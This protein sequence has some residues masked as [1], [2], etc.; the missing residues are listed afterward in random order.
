MIMKSLVKSAA[1]LLLGGVMVAGTANAAEFEMRQA[2][3]LDDLLKLVKERA[4]FESAVNKDRERE[5]IQKK[6]QQQSMLNS[7]KAE[8][9]AQEQRSDRL[10]TQFEENERRLGQLQEQLDTRL[11]SLRELF[12]VLQQVAGDTVGV[13]E[14]SVVSAQ[15]P[16]RGEPSRC[17]PPR[18]VRARSLRASKKSKSSGLPFSSR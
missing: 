9:T 16:G 7:A 5:F 17:W 3:D 12:G 4:L 10:E 14:G 13:F 1:A 8:R 18:W 15:F 6:A 2:S 11:G